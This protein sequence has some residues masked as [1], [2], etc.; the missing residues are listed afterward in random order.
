M[1]KICSLKELEKKH[2]EMIKAAGNASFVD[3]AAELLIV[4]GGIAVKPG[5]TVKWIH[6]LSAGVDAL[7]TEDIIKSD[8]I[9]T[10]SR[11]VHPIPI[12][13]HVLGMML[14]FERGFMQ[15]F[16]DQLARRWSQP[17]VSELHGKTALVVGVGEI[18]KKIAE[19]CRAFSMR[20]LGIKRSACSM[21]CVDEMHGLEDIDRLLPLADYVIIA[22]PLTKE[23]YHLF[24]RAQFKEMK[25]S[26][27]IINIGRGSIIDE[28]ELID[29][30]RSRRIAGAGLDVF[31]R[32][33][34]PESSPLYEMGNVMITSHYSGLTP[35]YMDR[36]ID[37]FCK[38]LAAYTE[39]RAMPTLVDKKRGY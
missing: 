26:A 10:N 31:E 38:N 13:E 4:P 3:E 17:A 29:A 7:L 15:A 5:K 22:L 14:A 36:A 25:K 27:C 16:Q 30:L 2:I 19:L 28:P 39:G 6:A 1:V 37:I 18:G 8:I 11:G 23:T 34:L 33:P 24:G 32:E 9:V 35:R 12:A 21:P 20:V